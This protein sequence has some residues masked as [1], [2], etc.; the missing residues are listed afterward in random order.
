MQSPDSL[1]NDLNNKEEEL[2]TRNEVLAI[3]V[4]NNIELTGKVQDFTRELKEKT[5]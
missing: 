1:K 5:P 4:C 2:K 3:L